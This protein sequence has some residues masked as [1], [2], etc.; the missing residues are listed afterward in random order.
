MYASAAAKPDAKPERI[1]LFVSSLVGVR[2]ARHRMDVFMRAL[3]LCA[4]I[5]AESSVVWAETSEQNDKLSIILEGGVIMRDERV[6]DLKGEPKLSREVVLPTKGV[7]YLWLKATHLS[8]TPAGQSRDA[9]TPAMIK[10]DLDGKQPLKGPRAQLPIPPYVTS[11]WLAY[12]RANRA[13]M[14]QVYV[15]EPGTHVLNL[16][17][18]SGAVTLEKVALTLFDAAEPNGDSL[19][20]TQDPGRGRATFPASPVQVDGFREDWQSPPIQAAGTTYYV[21]SERGSDENDGTSGETAWK[22]FVKMNAKTFGPGDAILLRRSAT[23]HEGLAPK[24]SGTP[25]APIS[26][27]AYGEGSRPLVNGVNRP[28]VSLADQSHWVIQDLQATSDVEYGDK[29]GGILVQHRNAESRPKAITIRNCI[30]F[31]SGQHG[32][33]VGAPWDTAAR[34]CDG[35]VI[36]NCLAFANAGAGIEVGG[37]SRSG[38]RNTVIRNCTAY[39]NSGMAGIWIHSGENGLIERCV[40]Y[41]NAVFQIWTWNSANVTIRYC[42]AYRSLAIGDRGGFDIDWDCQACTLEYCYS[43]HNQGPGMLLMGSGAG[44]YAGFPKYSRYNLC[45]YNI[46]A[47]D[48]GIVVMEN[49]EDGKVYNNV[50]VAHNT[51]WSTR[52]QGRAALDVFGWTV[53][54]HSGGWPARNEFR[55][56]ILVGLNGAVTLWVDEDAAKLGN[57]FDNNLHWQIGG[58]GLLIKWGGRWLQKPAEYANLSQFQEA[59]RQE[60]HGVQADPKLVGAGASGIGRLPLDAYRLNEGSPARAAGRKVVLSEEWLAERRKFLTETGAETYGIPMDPQPARE[61][62]WG[63]KLESE[64]KV[65]IGAHAGG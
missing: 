42:E 26:I 3:L 21:D 19:D 52:D 51:D 34:G 1:D 50:V 65:S 39:A 43:H 29:G 63:G 28:G 36:E 9:A 16:E 32:I 6:G 23:W 18:D 45:R 44:E 17:I 11:Q 40:G 31:D 53:Y 54:E 4:V 55:N 7:W 56:N 15:D 35:V 33:A 38:G 48:G 61:D 27:A 37:F 49:F 13:F 57:V 41:N 22:S 2:E 14:A 62:Y 24:G 30:A 10:Y 47:N 64:E 58:A 8:K 20:H 5:A 60:A 12:T 25:D 59:T 46:S